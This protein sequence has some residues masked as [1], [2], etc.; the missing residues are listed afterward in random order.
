MAKIGREKAH[1]DGTKKVSSHYELNASDNPGSLIT[2]VQLRG[3]N[4]E[5]WAKA[6]R[7]SLR[8][9]RKWGFM[10]GTHKEP[11]TDA[12]EMEDWWTVQSMI[13][14]W[15]LN[16]I[17]PNLRSTITAIKCASNRP[18]AFTKSSLCN[19]G[20]GGENEKHHPIQGG[21][22][23][24]RGPCSPGRIQNKGRR[25]AKDKSVVCSHCG[26]TGHDAK[27][28]FQIIGYPEWWGDRS[29]TDGGT[30]EPRQGSSGGRG[31][32]SAAH[33]NVAHVFG[34]SCS[35]PGTTENNHEIARLS[36]EQWKTLM[37]MIK[38]HNTSN[39]ETMTG[40]KAC[41]WWII[42]SGTSNHMTGR[43]QNLCDKRVIQN[44]PVGLPNGEIVFAN[45]EGI[46]LTSRMLIGV[47][48][49]NDGLYMYRGVSGKACHTKAEDQLELWHKRLDPSYK[50]VQM[51]PNMS[52]NCKNK[53]MN[54]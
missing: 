24:G 14:S 41:D 26:K 6:V 51:V 47:G 10:D 15:I 36:N 27:G 5:E 52:G 53:S 11:E 7:I 40:K 33:A 44:C 21:K 31:R 49:R 54:K 19:Y 16:T 25:E 13:V 30:S 46:D 43:L 38:S 20:A 50:I 17:E 1:D 48:E 32:G 3:E 22:G 29:R 28:C 45:K 9:R 18:L 8:A 23:N 4:Y 39:I 42:D 35:A 34:G 37:T 12:P 2:Q